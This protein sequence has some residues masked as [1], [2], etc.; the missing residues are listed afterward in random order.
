MKSLLPRGACRHLFFLENGILDLDG[1][2]RTT[3]VLG[4]VL[5]RLRFVRLAK[6]RY[7]EFHPRKSQEFKRSAVS[8][9]GVV[10]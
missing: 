4:P 9:Q 6:L 7:H 8:R 1:S 10:L 2:V 5:P 3:D